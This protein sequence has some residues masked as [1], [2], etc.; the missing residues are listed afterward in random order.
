MIMLIGMVLSGSY[1]PLQLWPKFMQS[2]LILQPFAGY[3]DIPIRLYIGTLSAQGAI[4][5]VGLQLVWS[6]VFI[7]AGKLL[8]A[9][10][11][12]SIIVQGG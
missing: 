12:K 9:K 7:I 6:M 11:L 3:L 10:R 2:F 4:L 8:M 1:L 5:A